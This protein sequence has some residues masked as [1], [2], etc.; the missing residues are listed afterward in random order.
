M[1][2]CPRCEAKLRATVVD[3]ISIDECPTCKGIWFDHDELRQAKDLTEPD[4]VWLDFDIWKQEEKLQPKAGGLTCP[5]CQ[6]PMCSLAYEGTQ[7]VIDCCGK[8][9]GIWIDKDELENIVI[10]LDEQANR[11]SAKQY[12]KAT[13]QEAIELIN[14]PESL[15]S[16]WGDFKAVWRLLKLRLV[17]ERPGLYQKLSIF[18]NNPLNL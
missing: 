16:E 3:E 9:K 4:L 1:I 6:T 5:K 14:G 10:S 17:V 15:V 12:L 7:V 8:C 11:M 18:Q 13:L 2:K